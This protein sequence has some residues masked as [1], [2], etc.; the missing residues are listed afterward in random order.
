MG[1]SST[2]TITSSGS[3]S[4][5]DV[6]SIVS[7]LMAVEKQSLT[8]YDKQ[9]AS[10]QAKLS[11]FGTLKG[12]LSTL[13]SAVSA[14]ATV[15]KF[16]TIKA[17]VSDSTNVSVSGDNSAAPGTYAIEVQQLAQAQKLKSAS[18]ANTTDSLGSGTLTFDFGTYDADGGF[19]LNPL[20]SSQSISIPAEADSLAAVRD[21]INS[22]NV[23]VTASIINDGSG[24][25]LV[26]ASKDTG[27]AS[28]LRIQVADNDGND[29]D[30]AG[31]SVLTYDA[32]IGGTQNLSEAV[33]A[34]NSTVI[35]DGITVSKPGN[36][37]S[38]AMQGVTLTLNKAEPGKTAILSVARDN[39]SIQ[40][41]VQAF[42]K[43]YNDLNSN[44]TNLSKYDATT[45]TAGL[46]Q[47]DSTVRGIQS[48]MRALVSNALP[49]AGGG[50]TR[51][52]DIG[53]AFQKDGSLS[54]DSAKLTTV[55]A[56]PSK[57][58]STLFASVAKPT[59]SLV[60][61]NTASSNAQA[62]SYPLHI[63]QLATHGQAT[64]SAAAATAIVAGVNDT[65]EVRID[66]LSGSVT[67]SPGSYTA[68]QLAAALQAKI[69]G[70]NEISDSGSSVSVT[71]SGGILKIASDRWGSASVVNLI[72]GNAL[73]D[74]FGTPVNT[75]GVDVAGSIGGSAATGS[76]QKLSNGDLSVNI[77]GGAIG[78]RGSVTY[79]SGF[80][81]QLSKMA[82][83]M[84]SSS[85]LIVTR[86]DGLNASIKQVDKARDDRNTE[87]VAIE[88]RY[89]A[90][91][92]A[93]DT[94]LSSMQATS[95]YLT[96]Q[97][98]SL[99]KFNNND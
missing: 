88:A 13:N 85:G 48:R 18:F 56:D 24:N 96:T 77:I 73:A 64:G 26:V 93:L 68:D 1:I 58:I 35:I 62:G 16:S 65:L 37:I 27:E 25:R 41:S 83:T 19:T 71:Q 11:A 23:G 46:L 5:L 55:M 47:G 28:A 14:L 75:D 74:L 72:G 36:S 49:V 15:D 99:P 20:K 89:R 87:L 22:A 50:L 44:I 6:D 63:T 82:T 42:V 38:D 80:A 31:L 9:E 7:Q 3:V 10:Y 59:D 60:Q 70:S 32:S 30:A 86:T 21:A 84:I 12:A 97:L 95:Q 92:T 4:G 8:K 45:K 34:K 52:S 57:D 2:G 33:A 91:F 76:G 54:L 66:G 43:A 94:L 53:I 29:T 67:L 51:L 39:A 81:A 61:F 78:D 79:A 69:N 40:S 98:A 17:S 90:Q